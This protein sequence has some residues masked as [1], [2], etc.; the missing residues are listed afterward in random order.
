MGL[1][2]IYEKRAH[3]PVQVIP[4]RNNNTAFAQPL[5]NAVL[6][7]WLACSSL[8][9]MPSRN[10]QCKQ[11]RNNSI[12]LKKLISKSSFLLPEPFTYL[13]LTWVYRI[14]TI[15]LWSLSHSMPLECLSGG[16]SEEQFFFYCYSDFLFPFI[17]QLVF[18]WLLNLHQASSSL[19]RSWHP[20]PL[21]LK[22][23]VVIQ[24]EVKICALNMTPQ[25]FQLLSPN[26]ERIYAY[27]FMY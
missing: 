6:N 19:G 23:L 20:F 10:K 18:L 12:F 27:S 2:F 14:L 24:K 13:A 26:S 7:Q 4:R 11:N 1:L 8:I 17:L 9:K 21:L 25:S 5:T 16:H 15:F 3:V 22:Y